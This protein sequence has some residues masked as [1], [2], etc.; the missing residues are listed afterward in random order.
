MREILG[1][2]ENPLNCHKRDTLQETSVLSHKFVA[3]LSCAG[4]P[5]GCSFRTAILP[6]VRFERPHNP[7]SHHRVGTEEHASRSATSSWAAREDYEA[8]GA[9]QIA[10]DN[11]DCGLEEHPRGAPAALSYSH[12]L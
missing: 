7:N 1:G 8:K 3:N 4:A 11:F 9:V 12:V 2:L 5:R 6:Q 10:T